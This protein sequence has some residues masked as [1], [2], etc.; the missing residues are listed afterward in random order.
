MARAACAAIVGRVDVA[1]G[2]APAP[3][4]SPPSRSSRRSGRRRPAGAPL[5]F[6]RDIDGSAALWM[7]GAE[8]R[9]GDP[10]DGEACRP[11]AAARATP[12]S[13]RAGRCHP[14]HPRRCPSLG[15]RPTPPPA[16]RVPD[17]STLIVHSLTRS[18]AIH[19]LTRQRRPSRPRTRVTAESAT[20]T[21]W[22]TSSSRRSRLWAD[23]L[24][25]TPRL[26]SAQI[27]DTA[28]SAASV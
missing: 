6:P 28:E 21:R 11:R 27:R 26:S 2:P 3:R 9:V 1:L 5:M 16:R 14:G 25:A 15:R 24:V 10:L 17:A 22:S 20:A 13:C 7:K 19:Q 18:T 23:L 4:R 12:D 8:T